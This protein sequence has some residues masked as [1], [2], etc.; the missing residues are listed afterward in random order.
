MAEKS[1]LIR[2]LPP[3]PAAM[4]AENKPRSAPLR[5]AV[6]GTGGVAQRNYLPFLAA[7][8]YVALACWNR[9]PEK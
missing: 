9:S 2:P 3:T 4:S 8:P 6:A 5:I 1:G 7:Q